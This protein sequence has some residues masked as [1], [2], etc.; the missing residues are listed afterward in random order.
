MRSHE[1]ARLLIDKALEDEYAMNRLIDDPQ[2][3]D[4]I[5]GFHAQQ[6]VEK[7]LKAVLTVH[8]IAYRHTHD[9][10]ELLDLLQDNSVEYPSELEEVVALTPF[11]AEFRYDRMPSPPRSQ[12]PFKRGWVKNCVEQTRQWAES[13]IV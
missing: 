13:I 8:A 1:L 7:T 9:L 2:A 11:A 3:A 6:A 12:R 10:T 5:V 4:E